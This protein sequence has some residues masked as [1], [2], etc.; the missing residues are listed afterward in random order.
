MKLW[1]EIWYAY[2]SRSA[3]IYQERFC[4]G[5]GD[6]HDARKADAHLAKAIYHRGQL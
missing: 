5:W 2:H 4:A 1:H 3:R 6:C